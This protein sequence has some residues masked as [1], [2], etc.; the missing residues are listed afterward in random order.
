MQHS[1]TIGLARMHAE[2]GERR[3]FLPDFVA[4]L[5]I[6]RYQVYLEQGYGSG[7]GLTEKDY[8]QIAPAVKFV[9]WREVY[10][11]DYV[12]VLR[13]PGDEVIRWMNPYSCLVSMLHYPTRPRRVEMLRSLNLDA[14][15]LDSIKDDTG[16]RLVENLKSVAWNGV[17]V[18]FDI[19]KGI[20]PNPL[21]FESPT[22]RPVQVTLLG[23][24]AV[25]S[26]VI[27]AAIR[28]A[29]E[30]YRKKMYALG[31]PGVLVNV[32]DYDLTCHPD[33]MEAILRRT[34]ILIDATQ[35]KEPSRPVIPNVWL[36]ALP[37]HAVLL[38]LSVDP[39]D[40]N[41]EPPEVKGIEGIPQGDLDQYIFAPDDPAYDRLPAEIDRRNRRFA[42]SCYSW[43]GIHPRE[44]MDIY[45]KQLRPIFRTIIESNGVEHIS[46]DGNYF[47]RAVARAMLSRW[48]PEG[49]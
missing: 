23:A 43:P 26:Q 28:Y 17:E 34:D 10:Q 5:E 37:A 49:E 35:R 29:D 44:C 25:G 18:A 33:T 13:Y 6:N 15:S 19:L 12:L 32:L 39:Y 31:V 24:G 40:F 38:D 36:E 20:Y 4:G 42:A 27:Q 11:Q 14:I 16:R 47:H 46:P 9:P 8:R 45:G 7:L 30:A 48:Q 22:R 21:G 41:V 3:D 1:L 2:A